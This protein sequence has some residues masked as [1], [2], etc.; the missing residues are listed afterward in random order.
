MPIKPVIKICRLGKSQPGKV[1]PLLVQLETE[2]CARDLIM[3]S[4]VR[5]HLLRNRDKGMN[6][7]INPDL[8]LAEAH[9]AYLLRQKR[10]AQQRVGIQQHLTV[11]ADSDTVGSAVNGT[12]LMPHSDTTG[13]ESAAVCLSPDALVFNPGS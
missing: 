2:D 6:I 12:C 13:T 8:T 3:S 5:G 4:R 9:A 7:Y 11:V 1:Q 10:R